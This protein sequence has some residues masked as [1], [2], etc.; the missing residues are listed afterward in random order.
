MTTRK[1]SRQELIDL[2]HRFVAVES[3]GITAVRGQGAGVLDAVRGQLATEDLGS[4]PAGEEAFARWLDACTERVLDALPDTVDGRPWGTARKAVNLFL[5]TCTYNHYLRCH[6][7]LARVE[8]LL[9]V[10]VDSVVA[11]ALKREAGR[12]QLPVWNGLKRLTPEEHAQFQDYAGE[13]A[14]RRGF[15]CRVH[16]D[17]DLWLSNR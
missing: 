5:R 1:Q 3:V 10:P 9:E 4:I 12:G 13:L 8:P 2:V 14:R 11:G 16:L 6:Y 7:Q 17:M 15:S